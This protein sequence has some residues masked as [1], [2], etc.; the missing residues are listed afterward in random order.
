[1]RQLPLPVQLRASSIFASFYAGPNAGV[2]AQLKS[3]ASGTRLPSVWVHGVASVGKT[4]LLQAVCAQAGERGAT[5]GY[6]PLSDTTLQS[7]AL[8]GCESLSF[9]CIDDFERI[10]GQAAWEHAVFR[11]FTELEEIGGRLLIASSSPPTATQIA[12][13]DLASRL[14]AGS[15][16]RLRSLGD[17]EQIAALQLR[18]ATLGMELMTDAAQFLVR[19]LP[20]D[21]ATLCSA[22]DRLDQAS[23]ATQRRLTLPFVRDFL[24]EAQGNR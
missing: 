8:V 23:L 17:N 2:V 18:A 24:D 20:R 7:D 16:L 22:L 9:V 11:L 21:M 5:A 12:L 6:F 14:G 1:M 4:H 19:R 10:A 3:L 15:V 13:K